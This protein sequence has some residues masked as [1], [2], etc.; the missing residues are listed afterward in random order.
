MLMLLLLP[1]YS[2]EA[3]PSGVRKENLLVALADLYHM[4]DFNE[5]RVGAV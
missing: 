4:I 2:R 3:I 5:R 1:L